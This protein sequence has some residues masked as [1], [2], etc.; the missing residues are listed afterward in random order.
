[1][2]KLYTA[3]INGRHGGMI[4]TNAW[5]TWNEAQAEVLAWVQEWWPSE[6]GNDTPIPDNPEDA[7]RQYF[8]NVDDE[9]Y[10]ICD[11]T[12]PP[13]FAVALTMR[14]ALDMAVTAWADQFDGKEGVDPN[15]NGADLVDWFSEW[16]K[17]AKA[18][19]ATAHTEDETPR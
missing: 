18:I 5:A 10:E 1:M 4:A 6:I 2:T 9:D 19:L 12:L 7:I 8:E 11:L 13:T 16:R 17:T 15:V 3:I 14:A